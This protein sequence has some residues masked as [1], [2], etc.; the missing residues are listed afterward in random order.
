MGAHLPRTF[1]GLFLIVPKYISTCIWL[2]SVCF[3]DTMFSMVSLH[4]RLNISCFAIKITVFTIGSLF[5]LPSNIDVLSRNSLVLIL[6]V[7]HTFKSCQ[8][9]ACIGQS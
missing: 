5:A 8:M 1:A 3:N 2:I 9:D 7:N 6:W 4:F